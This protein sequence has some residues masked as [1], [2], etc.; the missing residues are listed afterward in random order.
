M[1]FHNAN[2]N[3]S[4]VDNANMVGVRIV[5]ENIHDGTSRF[6]RT[7]SEPVLREGTH[8]VLVECLLQGHLSIFVKIKRF[9]TV[10]PVFAKG[11]VTVLCRSA[12]GCRE[13]LRGKPK[14]LPCR[15]G[16]KKQG[17]YKINMKV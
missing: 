17:N 14:S 1:P 3:I 4:G 9:F 12:G 2:G 6:S 13:A 7:E 11:K 10:M 8:A 16:F 5:S 15:S